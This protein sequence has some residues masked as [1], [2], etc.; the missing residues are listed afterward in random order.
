MLLEGIEIM[1]NENLVVEENTETNQEQAEVLENE[2]VVKTEPKINNGGRILHKILS[3]ALLVVASL[4]MVSVILGATIQKDYGFGFNDPT[5]ITIYT[6]NTSSP[7]YGQT[8][9]KDSEEYNKFMTLFNNSFKTKFFSAMFQGKASEGVT[10]K[11]GYKSF[12]SLTGTYVEF[13][14]DEVQKII[15]DGKEYKAE[16]VSNTDYISIVIEIN[17]SE[18][19]AEVNAYF[20][21]GT[22]GSNNSSYVRFVTFAA[23]A[24]LYEFVE[25]I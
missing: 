18:N 3:I 15:F 10:V 7:K 22:S 9:T 2:N 13:Y 4:I 23:Q 8:L 5:N 12:G 14:Y 24:E 21:Y 17:D 11:E 19:L 16:T 25:G 1:E 20:K 6:S